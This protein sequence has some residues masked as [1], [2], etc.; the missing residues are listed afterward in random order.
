MYCFT[1][2]NTTIPIM[3]TAIH[4]GHQLSPGLEEEM[5]I[6]KAE[7]LREEDPYTGLFCDVVDCR[8]IAEKSRFEVDLNRPRARAVYR[9]PKDAWGI[10]VWHGLP[11]QQVIDDSLDYYDSFYGEVEEACRG[12]IARL[13]KIVVLDIHSYNHRR[14]GPDAPPADPQENPEVNLGVGSV[15]MKI[16]GDMI[17]DFEQRFAQQYVD[18]SPLDVRTNIRFTGGSFVRWLHRTFPEDVCGIAVEF[19]KTFMDEW[20]GELN[21]ANLNELKLA[22]HNALPALLNVVAK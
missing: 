20:S 14:L 16:W 8:V 5:K 11:S 13:G 22:L 6:S 4:H 21:H 1:G 7:R 9:T 12:L 15:N 17:E 18:G 2:F 19:K 3:A 10:Q